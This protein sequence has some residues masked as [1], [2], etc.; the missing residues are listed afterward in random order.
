[1]RPLANIHVYTM[2]SMSYTREVLRIIDPQHTFTGSTLCRQDG[3]ESL[4]EKELLHLFPQT[5][6]EVIV[7]SAEAKRGVTATAKAKR[8]RSLVGR[9]L[10]LDDREDAWDVLSRP[11]VLRCTPFRCWSDDGAPLPTPPV[12]DATLLDLLQIV[13][14]VRAD[15]ASGRAPNAA[16]ALH[17]RRRRVLAGVVVVFSGGLLQDSHHPERCAPWRM[18]ESLGAACEVKMDVARVT[19]VVSAQAE[20]GSVRKALGSSGPRPIVAVKPQWLLDTAARWHRQDEAL[21]AWAPAF[22]SACGR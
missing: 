11:S 2:G 9:A 1:M 20:T 10:V 7:S 13:K 8:H 21:Y 5:I 14:A 6:D 15:L 22:A 17:E 3:D 12:A 4:F 16:S 18:A 19:H